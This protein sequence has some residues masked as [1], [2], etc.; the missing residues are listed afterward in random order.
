MALQHLDLQRQSKAPGFENRQD[1]RFPLGVDR[2]QGMMALGEA[3][4][5][6]VS[7]MIESTRFKDIAKGRKALLGQWF[8]QKGVHKA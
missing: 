7:G 4:V 1:R 8:G 3:I 5:D 2:A 6:G